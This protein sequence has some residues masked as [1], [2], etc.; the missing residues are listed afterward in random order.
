MSGNY[1]Y[2]V[3]RGIS[4]VEVMVAMIILA[5]AG[6][7]LVRLQSQSVNALAHLEERLFAGIAAENRMTD[8]Y[9]NSL[10][11]TDQNQQVA[12]Q[13]DIAGRQFNRNIHIQPTSESGFYRVRIDVNR[14]PQSAVIFSLEG[15]IDADK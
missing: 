8:Y 12:E 11:L 5:V 14:S 3:Q 15:Y 10:E 1:R 2:R 7:A 9:L 4:L 13:V 6:V